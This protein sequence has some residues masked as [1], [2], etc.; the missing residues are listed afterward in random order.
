MLITKA[1]PEDLETIVELEKE[2]DVIWGKSGLSKIFENPYLTFVVIT[3]E[4]VISAMVIT[5][6]AGNE[7]QI[8]N[9]VVHPKSRKLGTATQLIKHVAHQPE[10][11]DV[12]SVV[13]E[14]A[15]TNSAALG[16]YRKLGFEIIGE[17][18]SFYSDNKDAYTM[19]VQHKDL[20]NHS[21]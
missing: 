6:L 14:V 7:L 2:G 10:F 4:N 16:L 9:I 1:N 13:L 3:K 20:L 19:A 8:S 21:L 11:G 5:I 15:Q 18:K 12:D 17:R